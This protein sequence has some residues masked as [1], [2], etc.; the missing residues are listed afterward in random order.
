M[1]VFSKTFL[2]T[3]LFSGF[4]RTAEQTRP[5]CANRLSASVNPSSTDLQ[6]LATFQFTTRAIAI[7]SKQYDPLIMFCDFANLNILNILTSTIL[8]VS[9]SQA[10]EQNWH[11]ATPKKPHRTHPDVAP[12]FILRHVHD[13]DRRSSE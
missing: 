10:I 6:R 4:V 11:G 5:N 1:L 8:P 7:I 12:A 9:E 13:T 2:L 3:D